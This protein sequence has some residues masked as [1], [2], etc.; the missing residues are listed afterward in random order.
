MYIY[1][2]K[3]EHPK[4]KTYDCRAFTCVA[5]GLCELLT[6]SRLCYAGDVTLKLVDDNVFV[7]S[8]EGEV[9]LSW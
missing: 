5:T 1:I 8:V 7:D 6:E 3:A 9:S 2:R 4:L